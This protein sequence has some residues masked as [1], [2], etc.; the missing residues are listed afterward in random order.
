MHRCSAAVRIPWATSAF[1][2]DQASFAKAIP[3]MTIFV[4]AGVGAC[5]I[6]CSSKYAVTKACGRWSDSRCNRSTPTTRCGPAV[7]SWNLVIPVLVA[8]IGSG[9]TL[10]VVFQ[11]LDLRVL[12]QLLALQHAAQQQADDD[13][14]DCNFNQREAGLALAGATQ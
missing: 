12:N 9:N 11:I 6:E 8:V 13:E 1:T 10:V 14:D 5:C 3:E 2:G 4:G 7:I